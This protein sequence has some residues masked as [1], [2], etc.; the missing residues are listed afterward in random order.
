MVLVFTAEILQGVGEWDVKGR[1]WLSTIPARTTV[2]PFARIVIKSFLTVTRRFLSKVRDLF[3]ITR[4][5]KATY[6][7]G[8]VHFSWTSGPRLDPSSSCLHMR[9]LS[10]LGC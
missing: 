6:V 4:Q 8:T 10:L 7:R 1:A 2:Q 5:E 9:I 3:P